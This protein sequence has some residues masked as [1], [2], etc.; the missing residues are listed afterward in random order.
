MNHAELEQVIKDSGMKKYVVA[1][2]IGT[3][4]TS[5]YLKM[6]GERDFSLS[7]VQKL[8]AVLHI[9][10]DL[11]RRIFFDVDV[12]NTSTQDGGDT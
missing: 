1:D 12:D 6:N 8:K 4:R 3:N 11:F 2:K 7:E 5:F 9:P 10:D